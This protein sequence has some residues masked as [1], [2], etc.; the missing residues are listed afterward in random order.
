MEACGSSKSGSDFF[1]PEDVEPLALASAAAAVGAWVVA[2]PDEGEDSVLVLRAFAGGAPASLIS[3]CRTP[4]L[5]VADAV[6]EDGCSA[7]VA[8]AAADVLAEF[9]N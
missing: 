4:L 8:V 7:A 9:F 3:R 1:A 2:V 5:E 6:T